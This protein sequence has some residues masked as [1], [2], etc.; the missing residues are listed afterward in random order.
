MESLAFH[1]PYLPLP[2]PHV[3]MTV[4]HGITKRLLAE[5]GASSAP[6]SDPERS[7]VDP[8]SQSPEL[9]HRHL[10]PFSIHVGASCVTS[11]FL[12]SGMT[13]PEED[14]D[15]GQGSKYCLVAIGRLQVRVGSR[16]F[17]SQSGLSVM[18][19]SSLQIWARLLSSCE[20]GTGSLSH[21]GRRRGWIREQRGGASCRVLASRGSGSVHPPRLCPLLQSR[22]L[23]TSCL[24]SHLGCVLVV[25]RTKQELLRHSRSL[26]PSP[27]HTPLL[28]QPT[29]PLSIGSSCLVLLVPPLPESRLPLYSA[30]RPS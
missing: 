10:C 9:N 22:V 25:R 12:V 17:P 8:Y 4:C 1:L 15:V 27:S 23:L 26:L 21:S 28:S 5:R 3:P 13:I 18:K 11:A 19:G 30:S 20:L 29:L 24:F 14:A 2:R 7:A 6:V 16:L